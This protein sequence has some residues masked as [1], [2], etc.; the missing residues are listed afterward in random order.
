MHG[1]DLK[2]IGH[3]FLGLIKSDVCKISTEEA[4]NY[5]NW[6]LIICTRRKH[7]YFTHKPVMAVRNS[8]IIVLYSFDL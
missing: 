3:R 5:D 2:R 1:C 6:D 8:L 7:N 4:S